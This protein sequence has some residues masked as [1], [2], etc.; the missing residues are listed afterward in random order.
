MPNDF[1]EAAR[2]LRE[3]L[4]ELGPE[5]FHR[6]SEQWAQECSGRYL[7]SREYAKHLARISERP[8]RGHLR[9]V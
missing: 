1:E 5:E 3:E 8:T 9:L 7:Q 6:R 4:A 2:A